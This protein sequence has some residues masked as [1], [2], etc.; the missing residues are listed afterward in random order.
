[1]ISSEFHFVSLIII[2]VMKLLIFSI[3]K[4]YVYCFKRT[5]RKLL[6]KGSGEKSNQK[7]ICLYINSFTVVAV[8]FDRTYAKWRAPV[9]VCDAKIRLEAKH[10]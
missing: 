9:N 5:Q 3:D 8:T 2:V 1:M 4:L 10:E 6:A 7:S